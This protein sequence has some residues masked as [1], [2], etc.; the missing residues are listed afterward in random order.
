LAARLAEKAAHL[1]LAL[2]QAAAPEREPVVEGLALIPPGRISAAPVAPVVER[3]ISGPVI[4][5]AQEISAAIA[6]AVA[7]K[8]S[9]AVIAQAVA[10]V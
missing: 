3:R 2:A 6:Q 8:I 5:L 7:R 1:E 4:A 10:R 9:E